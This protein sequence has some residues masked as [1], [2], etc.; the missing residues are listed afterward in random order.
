MDKLRREIKRINKYNLEYYNSLLDIVDRYIEEKPDIPIET[1]KAVIEGISK[2]ILH[3]L[4]QEPIGTLNKK[5]LQDL[6]KEALWAL[7]H[8][9]IALDLEFVL[10][11]GTVIRCL[12][13][14]IGRAH[15]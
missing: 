5:N 6:F 4:K 2:L 10:H 11:I 14:E 9:G 7:Q 13:E 15:V 3:V 12:G 8:K 1:C